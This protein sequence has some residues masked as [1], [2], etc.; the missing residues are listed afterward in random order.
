LKDGAKPER[1]KQY[2]ENGKR[3]REN[4][5]TKQYIKDNPEKA[6]QYA[7]NH[8][9]HDISTKEWENCL[10]VFDYGCAYCGI[11]QEEARK[12]D[13]QNLHREHVE[14]NGY[15]DLRNGVPACRG[16]NDKKWAFEMLEWYKQQPFFS[17]E[18]LQ[19]ILWWINEGYKKYIEVKPPYK[20][21][22]KRIY[23]KDGTYTIQHELW[24]VDE[25]RN[26]TECILIG[27]SKKEVEG[28]YKNITKSQ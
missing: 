12:R 23:K 18:R 22:R 3:Q 4:G 2:R 7:N 10:K 19:K 24:A 13:G 27:S 5:Y 9:I 6:K 1:R 15:N 14:H 11:S 28:K 17:E 25:K 16:C 26:M 21:T 20:L 8:R